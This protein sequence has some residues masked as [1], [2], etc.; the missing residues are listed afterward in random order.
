MI[1]GVELKL[2][3]GFKNDKEKRH[4][5]WPYQGVCD[6]QSGS[7]PHLPGSPLA[8]RGVGPRGLPVSK[9]MLLKSFI[10]KER[11]V[12]DSNKLIGTPTETTGTPKQKKTMV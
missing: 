2:F 10:T 6:F 7:A 4:E 5:R 8:P 9:V 1:A 3:E 11:H 12:K